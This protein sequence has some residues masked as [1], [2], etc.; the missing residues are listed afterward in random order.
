VFLAIT[1]LGKDAVLEMLPRVYRQRSSRSTQTGLDAGRSLEDC[2]STRPAGPSRAGTNGLRQPRISAL[3]A[4][5]S[6]KPRDPSAQVPVVRME[7]RSN[8]AMG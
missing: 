6:S 3:A 4:A 1:H 8:L 2:H 5:Y 7:A